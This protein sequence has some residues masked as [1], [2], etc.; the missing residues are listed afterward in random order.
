MPGQDT[1][2]RA[3]V[4]N[5][6]ERPNTT[7]IP[8]GVDLSAYNIDVSEPFG[9][10][11]GQDAPGPTTVMDPTTGYAVSSNPMGEGAGDQRVADVQRLLITEL[12]EEGATD[13]P[14][15]V[16]PGYGVDGIWRCETQTAYNQLLKEKG[17]EPCNTSAGKSSVNCN[18]VN[19]PACAMDEETLEKLKEAKTNEQE[20]EQEEEEQPQEEELPKFDDQCF[21]ITNIK[22]V[23]EKSEPPAVGVTFHELPQAPLTD[24]TKIKYKNIHKLTT[25]DPATIMNR[26]RLTKGCTEFLN[27]R[28]F[29]LS[30]LTP[31]IRIYKQYYEGPKKTPR[32][33]ELEFSS[34]VDPV[35]DL[36]SMLDS[37]LQRGVGVG[38]ESFTFDFQGVQPA[39]AKK[40]IVANL[41]IYAQNFNELFKFRQGVDQNGKPLEGGYR[42]IDLVLLEPKYRFM[43]EK[44]TNQKLREFNPNFYEIKVRAGW[45]ATGGGGL[46]PDDLTSAI[47]DN[48]VEMFLVVVEHEFEFQDDGSVRLKLQFRARIESLLLDKRSDVLFDPATIARRDERRNKINEIALAKSQLSSQKVKCEEDTLKQLRALYEETVE[49][50]RE[51]SYLSILKQMMIEGCIYT[52]TIGT[53]TALRRPD[54]SPFAELD[55]T[56]NNYSCDDGE[57]LTKPNILE[58][59]VRRVNFFYLGDL[60]ALAVNNVLEKVENSSTDLRKINYGNIKFVLGPAPFDN[61]KVQVNENILSLNIADIPIS[62]DLFTDFMREKVIKGRKNTYPLLVFMRDAMYDLVFEALGPECRGGDQRI[63]LLL[64][65]AQI[66]ADSTAGGGDPMAEKIGENIELDLDEYGKNLPIPSADSAGLFGRKNRSQKT[67]KFVFDSFNKKSLDRSYEYFIVYA[68]GKEPRRL[69]FDRSDGEHGS[70]YE[71]DL[72]NG[73]FHTTTGL[74]R[75]L[76]KNMQFSRTDQPYLREAR[77]EQSDFKPE[78]QLSNVYNTTIE[79]YGNNLFFPGCQVYVNPRGLGSD[80][81]GDPGT[82]NSYANIMGLGGYHIVKTVSH[83]IGLNG[84][85]TTLNCLFTTSGDGLGSVMTANSRVGDTVILECA[86]LEREIDNIASSMGGNIKRSPDSSGGEP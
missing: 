76:V 56:V 55:F 38:I 77:Y 74:D 1:D 43:T 21:L 28:H 53:P 31:S 66:S 36:Q 63:S 41:T 6:S 18:G 62:V 64:D 25:T 61:P 16:L 17:I 32:E 24:R 51:D 29:Q 84:Y 42:I 45:A 48:Q 47:K 33:V 3:A 68:F 75:G 4:E 44:G 65:S 26:L 50:E 34:Y 37:S 80:E 58:P 2:Q 54:L 59:G 67:A 71:R 40:D 83:S 73:I 86:D 15:G 35:K 14:S 49:K 20:E 72:S 7:D 9:Y 57:L 8:G 46:L 19:T 11:A 85:T 5:P 81:L 79:M 30:Q 70:R 23:F 69:A 12:D 52:A 10:G 22:E 82:K 27:I 13:Q 60:Y 39:T 78:L